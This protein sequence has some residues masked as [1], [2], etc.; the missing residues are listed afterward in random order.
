[1]TGTQNVVSGIATSPLN[2]ITYSDSTGIGFSNAAYSQNMTSSLI[3]AAIGM[4]GA[5]TTSVL[6]YLNTD[7]MGEKLLGFS[8]QNESDVAKFHQT[9]GSVTGEGVNYTLTGDFSL[10]LL[11]IGDFSQNP[12]VWGF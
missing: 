8:I 10:N 5:F 7:D 4:T 11:N 9:L 3:G 1:M 6:S 2:A 12:S